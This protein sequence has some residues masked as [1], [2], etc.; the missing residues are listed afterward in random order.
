MTLT[1]VEIAVAGWTVYTFEMPDRRPTAGTSQTTRWI[2]QMNLEA[3][4]YKNAFASTGAMYRLLQRTPGAHGRALCLRHRSTAVSEGL[5]SGTEWDAMVE[6]LHT[7]VRSITLVPVT[8]AV[9]ACA[10]F[11]ET[12]A[13]AALV[14][15]L[16]FE[17]PAEWDEEEGEEEHEGESGEEGEGETDSDDGGGNHGGGECSVGERSSTVSLAATEELNNSEGEERGEGPVAIE[18]ENVDGETTADMGHK[19]TKKSRCSAYTLIDVPAVLQQ[20]L[21]AFATWRMKTVNQHRDGGKVEPVTVAGNKADALRLLGWL[22]SERCITPSLGG[23]FGSDR[24]GDAVQVYIDHLIRLGRS[25]TTVTGYLTS[26]IAIARFVHSVRAAHVAPGAAVSNVPIDAMRRAHK[27]AKQ[28]E[29]LEQ[30]FARK[31]KAWL[32]WEEVQTAR[33]RA[34]RAYENGEEQDAG[35]ENHNQHRR[36]LFDATLLSWLTSVPPDRVAVTRR[37]QL[38]VSLK[39][40]AA[41]FDLDLSTP[42]AHKTAA[43]FGPTVTAVPTTVCKLLKAWIQLERLGTAPRQHVFVLSGNNTKPT[44]A[45]RWT[46]VVQAAFKRHSGVALSPKDLRSSFVTFLKSDQNSDEVLKSAAFAMRHS[47]K[48]Q[49]GAAYDKERASRLSAAA[50]AAAG[51]YAS[52]F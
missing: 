22:K 26:F 7:G 35:G 12:N 41:G 11:G 18:G 23:V 5:C 47:T 43:V 6:H 10:A 21:D 25:Y 48:Q 8:I 32:T 28:Q 49:G 27:Q 31:P 17:R 13:S 38:G 29:R 2:F 45:K 15:A 33:A 1:F 50:V 42:D 39:L 30:R 16:G 3:V 14:E 37:L 46:R 4:L 19:N 20:E 9:A 36:Q 34:V 24:L 40:T 52:Q 44:D 51:E